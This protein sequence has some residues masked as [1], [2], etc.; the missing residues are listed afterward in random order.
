[1]KTLPLTLLLFM[2]PARAGVPPPCGETETLIEVEGTFLPSLVNIFNNTGNGSYGVSSVDFFGSFV[3]TENGVWQGC[4]PKA[5]CF[6]TEI[7]FDEPSDAG[8]ITIKQ[9]DK[10]M[11]DRSIFSEF[12]ANKIFVEFGD[13]IP[14]C[15]EVSLL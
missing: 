7:R 1:M 2:P 5:D 11:E 13:C 10:V 12:N 8:S 9:D 15:E 14:T 6:I 4:L 3:E